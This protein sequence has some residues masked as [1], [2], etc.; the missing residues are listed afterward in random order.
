MSSGEWI[1][2]N[3]DPY[4]FSTEEEY[5]RHHYPEMCQGEKEF[6]NDEEGTSKS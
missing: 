6:F 1:I 2:D 3:L 5:Y 4:N